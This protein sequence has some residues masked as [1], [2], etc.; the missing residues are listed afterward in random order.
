MTDAVLQL[1]EHTHTLILA[2]VKPSYWMQSNYADSTIKKTY[3]A[4]TSKAKWYAL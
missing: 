1:T 2:S 4:T 3:D